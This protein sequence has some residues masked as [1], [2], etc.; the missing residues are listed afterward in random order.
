MKHMMGGAGGANAAT[1]ME[2][3]LARR[4]ESVDWNDPESAVELL[5]TRR[6]VRALTRHMREEFPKVAV[7]MVDERDDIMTRGLLEKCSGR[8][9]AVVGMAHMHGIEVRWREAQGGDGGAVTLIS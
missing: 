2:P 9:V 3:D 1:W 4:F 5:K 8:T 7:A 6:A